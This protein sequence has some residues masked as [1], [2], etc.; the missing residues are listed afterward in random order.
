[1]ENPLSG[2]KKN[3]PCEK[4]CWGNRMMIVGGQDRKGVMTRL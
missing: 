1:V 2:G 4:C 3:R